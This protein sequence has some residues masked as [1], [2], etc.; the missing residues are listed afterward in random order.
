MSSKTY[1]AADIPRELQR[2][3]DRTDR[4]IEQLYQLA[5]HSAALTAEKKIRTRRPAPPATRS[6]ARATRD[7]YYYTDPTVETE[8]EYGARGRSHNASRPPPPQQQQSLSSSASDEEEVQEDEEGSSVVDAYGRGPYR[9]LFRGAYA[10]D[11][12]EELSNKQRHHHHHHH[13]Q[14]RHPSRSTVDPLHSQHASFSPASTPYRTVHYAADTPFSSPASLKKPPRVSQP[15]LPSPSSFLSSSLASGGGF[16]QQLPPWRQRQQHHYEDQRTSAQNSSFFTAY[17]GSPSSAG[18]SAAYRTHLAAQQSTQRPA[19]HFS[20][21]SAGAATSRERGRSRS[22]LFPVVGDDSAN[23]AA[24]ESNS[25]LHDDL[26]APAHTHRRP[27]QQRTQQQRHEHNS[28]VFVSAPEMRTGGGPGSANDTSAASAGM[29]SQFGRRWG[30]VFEEMLTEAPPP[31]AARAK[32][33]RRK[34]AATQAAARDDSDSAHNTSGEDEESEP[35]K[36][37][38]AQVPSRAATSSTIHAAAEALAATARHRTPPRTSLNTSGV[39][40]P[41]PTTTNAALLNSPSQSMHYSTA[42]AR[43]V[44]Q[45]RAELRAKE[46]AMLQLRMNH[47]KEIAEVRQSFTLERAATAKHTADELST[48]YGIQQQVLQA[49]LQTERERVAEAEEQLRLTRRESAQR[50]LDFDDATHALTALQHKH[51]TLSTAHQELIAQSAQWRAD[52]EKSTATVRQLEAQEKVWKAKEVDWVTKD[53]QLQQRAEAA[54]ARVAQQESSAQEVL[55]QVEAEF[56]QTSQSYQDLLTE[57]TKRM[58]YLEK[59]HRK[60]KLLKELHA[61]LT[62]E[63]T[64]LIETTVQARQRQ[65]HEVSSVRAEVQELR[66]Q[67]HQRDSASQEASESYQETLRDYKRRL[68]LQEASAAERTKTLQQHVDTANH[69]IDLLRSQLEG[70]KQELVAEQGRSQQQQMEAAQAQLQAKEAL[71]DQQRSAAAYKLRTDDVMSQQ[72]RQLREKDTKLQALAASAAEPVQRLREQLEDERGRRA[73]LEEQ[74]KSYKRRAKEAEEH[75]AAE[76]RREQLRTALLTPSASTASGPLR[77]LR[78]ATATPSVRSTSTPRPTVA[79]VSAASTVAAGGEGVAAESGRRTTAKASTAAREERPPAAAVVLGTVKKDDAAPRISARSPTETH[80]RNGERG[81]S[82]T[83]GSTPAAPAAVAGAEKNVFAVSPNA[84]VQSLSGIS[85]SS[86]YTSTL[87][88]DGDLERAVAATT[89]ADG[90]VKGSEEHRSRGRRTPAHLPSAEAGDGED[91]DDDPV[92]P[93]LPWYAQ[94]PPR[95]RSREEVDVSGVAAATAAAP[96][97]PATAETGL[98]TTQVYADADAEAHEQRMRTFHSSAL[99]V[100]RRFAGSRS[101]A[102]ARCADIVKQTAAERRRVTLPSPSL[103]DE[104]GDGRRGTAAAARAAAAATEASG[105]DSELS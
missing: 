75:A 100:M 84:T 60:Y 34:A 98:A 2:L 77:L 6:E 57:A 69:T 5:G 49:S 95:Q 62:A 42:D 81:R 14:R 24:T 3:I 27:Q 52:L 20:G 39:V 90:G 44:E 79:G 85:R 48:T 45:L 59:S 89:S 61:A 31:G 66:Q 17:G 82:H 76:I 19:T 41:A 87:L 86:P 18:D 28:E 83:H 9:S 30:T 73:R 15:N 50:R 32:A 80:A 92:S 21:G 72:K 22:P 51:T 71:A 56:T 23:T 105:S 104:E 43:I 99:E 11:E 35:E 36:K 26:D 101:E 8:K 96:P 53:R 40:M 12:E 13:P 1:N 29:R 4:G 54:E 37:V 16:G 7:A 38:E 67:L 65:E 10:P 94:R 91:G 74:L 70:V 97:A 46:E 102:L 33:V 55:T 58:A 64:Q 78:S 25:G 63:H 47:A 103:D 68:E 93:A 88:G